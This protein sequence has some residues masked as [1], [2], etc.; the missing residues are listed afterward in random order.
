[1]QV[2]FFLM[3]LGSVASSAT[4]PRCIDDPAELERIQNTIRSHAKS[5]LKYQDYRQSLQRESDAEIVARLAYSETKAA[6]CAA[7]EGQILPLILST[8]GNRVRIRGGDVRSVVFQTDQFSSSLNL[9]PESRYREFLCPKDEILWGQALAQATSVL[10]GP[11][12]RSDVVHYFLFRHSPKWPK[13]PWNYPEATEG[14]TPQIRECVRFF[15]NAGW[16]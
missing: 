10:A 5:P 9:Y 2:L 7:I 13:P 4:L 11:S 16:K 8:I 15:H 3:L 6:N 1:M 14:T 12:P